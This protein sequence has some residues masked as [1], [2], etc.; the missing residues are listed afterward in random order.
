MGAQNAGMVA[1]ARKCRGAVSVAVQAAQ[2]LLG[3][4]KYRPSC[5]ICRVWTAWS[6]ILRSPADADSEGIW[7]WPV[8]GTVCRWFEIWDRRTKEGET[9]K[10]RSLKE[11][12]YPGCTFETS[13]PTVLVVREGKSEDQRRKF[14][15][16]RV[17]C[18]VLER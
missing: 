14:L 11:I 8:G 4:G 2:D 5:S 1:K 9:I 13:R 7:S 18:G 16:L 15:L 12:F 6:K 3:F 17:G 10:L